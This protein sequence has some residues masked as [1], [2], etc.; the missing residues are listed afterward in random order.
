MILLFSALFA[1]AVTHS[2]GGSVGIPR[3]S[4]ALVRTYNFFSSSSF[5]SSDVAKVGVL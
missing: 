4:N 5:Q 2:C 1:A 3:V